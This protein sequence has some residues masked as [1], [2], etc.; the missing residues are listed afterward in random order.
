MDSYLEE[1]KTTV[2]SIVSKVKELSKGESVSVRFGVVAYRDHPPQE[3]TYLTKVLD[4][5]KDNEALD[6]LQS[7]DC[8]GG[9]D[10]AEAV[11]DG[12]LEAAQSTTWRDS[13]SLPSLRYIFHITDAPPHGDFY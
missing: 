13:K 6:F 3:T 7:L 12:L 9:G 11:F 10:G 2:N 5:S 1:T 8:T 4:L